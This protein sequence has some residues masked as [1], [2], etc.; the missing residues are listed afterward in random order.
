MSSEDKYLPRGKPESPYEEDD[1]ESETLPFALGPEDDIKGA[2]EPPREFLAASCAGSLGCCL[3]LPRSASFTDVDESLMASLADTCVSDSGL[4]SGSTS[5]AMVMM[6][7]PGDSQHVWSGGKSDLMHTSPHSHAG[8]EPLTPFA[9][10]SRE[11]L[12]ITPPYGSSFADSSC[13]PDAIAEEGSMSATKTR[14]SGIVICPPSAESH[15]ASI[16]RGDYYYCDATLSPDLLFNCDEEGVAQQQKRSLNF[17]QLLQKAGGNNEN[18][19]DADSD[20]F[21]ILH[22]PRP[23]ADDRRPY[24]LGGVGKRLLPRRQTDEEGAD[25]ITPSA[26]SH[27]AS[28]IRGDYYYCDATLSPDLLFNCDEEG[29]A[30]QQK[31]SLNFTQLLQKAGGNNENEGDADSDDFWILHAPRPPADDRRPYPL[32]GVGKRLLPR[33]QTDE[34]G[35]DIIKQEEGAQSQDIGLFCRPL[36]TGGHS[37]GGG[38]PRTLTQDSES[39]APRSPAAV[40]LGDGA[41]HYRPHPIMK[42]ASTRKRTSVERLS[43]DSFRATCVLPFP[44]SIEEVIDTMSNPNLL[45]AWFEPVRMRQKLEGSAVEAVVVTRDDTA[46]RRRQQR[47]HVSPDGP[48]MMDRDDTEVEAEVEVETDRVYDGEWVEVAAPSL[49]P[50]ASSCA[51]S[52][53]DNLRSCLGFPRA[54]GVAMFIER[55]RGRLSL[56]VGPYGGG[57]VALHSIEVREVASDEGLGVGV[58]ITDRV[59]LE[60][61]IDASF[62][63]EPDLVDFLLSCGDTCHLLERCYSPSLTDFV[64][65]TAAS[66][67]SLRDLVTGGGLEALLASLGDKISGG[68][69]EVIEDDYDWRTPL[70]R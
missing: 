18:E 2:I 7:A 8:T 44:C 68:T 5:A 50:P 13:C 40:I 42:T 9:S 21:W 48:N 26:E 49:V 24:P 46:W 15:K 53:L 57:M 58:V 35:A 28:I 47:I 69:E 59:W 54:G 36:S 22:A 64:S 33:R 55:A 45:D 37:F 65:Q 62:D 16:I 60:Q 39:D 34:E 14:E 20:D 67:D 17:T 70:L 61:G 27:K 6:L 32:G 30:Q 41:P 23:P 29:V 25:I 52:V 11:K 1:N 56:T 38:E 43:S 63:T 19:G 10:L 12:P 3:P 31:R 66:L 4:L 51:H